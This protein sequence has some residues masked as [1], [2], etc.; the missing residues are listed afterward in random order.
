VWGA[1]L[2]AGGTSLACEPIWLTWPFSLFP[3]VCLALGAGS[4]A[5]GL[6]DW[7]SGL[8]A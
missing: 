2:L 3:L 5:I 7:W 4:T 1:L 6:A 8:K